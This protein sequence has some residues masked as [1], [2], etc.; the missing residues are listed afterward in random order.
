[1]IDTLRAIGSLDF[2]PA[3]EYGVF[4][5]MLAVEKGARTQWLMRFYDWAVFHTW[6]LPKNEVA[7]GDDGMPTTSE[8]DIF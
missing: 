2:Q 5:F 6:T 3:D 1:M 8:F 7:P 4:K